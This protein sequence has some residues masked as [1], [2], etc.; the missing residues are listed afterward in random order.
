MKVTV[1]V[2]ITDDRGLLISSKEYAY[3]VD[4]IEGNDSFK[5]MIKN[6]AILSKENIEIEEWR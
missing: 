6:N 2:I 1:K 3:S 5:E 4:N